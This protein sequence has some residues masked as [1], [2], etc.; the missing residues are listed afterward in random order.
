MHGCSTSVL[1]VNAEVGSMGGVVEGGVGIAN[2]TSPRKAAIE[3]VQ[4]ELRYGCY[5]A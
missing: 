1:I 5:A 4:A 2:K 3:K